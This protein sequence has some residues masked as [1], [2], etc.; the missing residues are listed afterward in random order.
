MAEKI[1]GAELPHLREWREYH[2]L[3]QTELAERAG[4]GRST[5]VRG[6]LGG[7]VGWPNVR[8]LAEALNV[9]PQQLQHEAPPAPKSNRAA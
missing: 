6:E 7:I 4:V 1:R 9:T 8:K 3:N 2:A 5:I